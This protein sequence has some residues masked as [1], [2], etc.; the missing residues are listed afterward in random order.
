[1]CEAPFQIKQRNRYES[2][3]LL[4]ATIM[5]IMMQY[6]VLTILSGLT[7]TMV[8]R[9]T[10]QYAQYVDHFDFLF[11]YPTL[12]KAVTLA[13]IVHCARRYVQ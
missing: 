1:M 6:Y 7:W 9:F 4:T 12:M 10:L 3:A 2:Y 13:M 11:S 5:E 8:S